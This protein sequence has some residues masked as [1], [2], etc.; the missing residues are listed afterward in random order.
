[1]SSCLAAAVDTS[2]TRPWTKGPRS[3]TRTSTERPFSMFTTRRQVPKGSFLWAA[4]SFLGS[5]FSPLAV[6]RPANPG[7]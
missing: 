2:T 5:N 1:M 4:V 7:P 3:L 6:G